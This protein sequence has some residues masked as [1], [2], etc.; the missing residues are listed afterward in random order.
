M[1]NDNIIENKYQNLIFL[2][3]QY[4]LKLTDSEHDSKHIEDVISNI[5]KL[6]SKLKIDF[7]LEVCILSAYWHDVGRTIQ[8]PGHEKISAKM[9]ETELKKSGYSDDFINKCYNAIEFHKWNMNPKTIEGLILKDADKLAWL[10]IGRW[11]SCL[12]NKQRLDEIMNLLP[13]LRNEIL[14]FEESKEIYDELIVKITK[15]LYNN[16]FD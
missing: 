8:G 13:K 3:K 15:Q 9:L 10:G 6:T 2:S 5:Y 16:I 14:Y 1:N 11:E 4:M 12:S 7:D